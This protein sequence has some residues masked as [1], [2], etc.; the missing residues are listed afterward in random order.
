MCFLVASFGSYRC[1]LVSVG[2]YPFYLNLFVYIG[3]YVFLL[4]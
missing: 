3:F 4:D 1:L 2:F